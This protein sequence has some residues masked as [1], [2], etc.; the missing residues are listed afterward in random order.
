MYRYF[1]LYKPCEMLSQFTQEQHGQITLKD[2]D[3]EFPKDVYPVGRLDSDSE[4]LLLLTNDVRLNSQLLDPKQQ[5]PRTYQ[6]QVEGDI[7]SEA[8][9]QLSRGVEISINGKKYRTAPCKAEK[10]SET[11]DFPPRNPPIRTRLYIPTSWISLTLTEG[12]NRQ[13]RRMTAKVGF[14]TLRLVRVAIGQLLLGDMQPG[15]VREIGTEALSGLIVSN[16]R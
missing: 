2:L 1:L 6:V 13:V 15:E 4:G 7:T 14:P 10:L 9:A 11:P 8:L 5:H 3:Y 16:K 12:K